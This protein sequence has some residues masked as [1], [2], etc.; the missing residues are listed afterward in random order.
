MNAHVVADEVITRFGDTKNGSNPLWAYGSRSIIRHA[1]CVY[2]VVPEI[3]LNLKPLCNTRWT[4][5]RRPDGGSWEQICAAPVFNEREPCLLALLPNGELL[6]STNP[7][8]SVNYTN[9]DGTSAWF[10]EPQLVFLDP[11]QPH[12][13]LRTIT[14]EWSKRHTFTEHSYRALAVDMQSGHIF[15][16]HQVLSGGSYDLAWVLMDSQG[17]Q[18]HEG[19]LLYPMRACYHQVAAQGGTVSIMGLSDEIDPNQEWHEF[20]EELTGPG[21]DFDMRQIYFTHTP[22]LLR[23]SFAPIATVAS[24]DETAGRTTNLDMYVDPA[25]DA[26]L[27]IIERNVWMCALRDRFF[28]CLPLTMA[29]H[30]VRVRDGRVISRQTLSEVVEDMNAPRPILPPKGADCWEYYRVDPTWLGENPK[31]VWATFHTDAEHG[32]HVLYTLQSGDDEQL[33]IREVYPSAS[34]P[35]RLVT[36]LP[37]GCFNTPSLRNGCAPSNTIDLYGYTGGINKPFCDDDVIR[38][39]QIRLEPSGEH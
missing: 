6:I 8:R 34:A 15:L 4:L 3:S 14:P 24:R 39:M 21:W 38:Y 10:C 28:P 9:P 32:L 37:L 31:P 36:E 27:L 33:W 30:Y 22:D 5:W 7:A 16:A 12:Q 29:L 19:K 11:R 20:K 18:L 13:P 25:G 2:A 23:Q 35:Q 26:H 1:N 17:H